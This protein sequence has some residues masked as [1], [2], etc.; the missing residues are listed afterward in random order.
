M[1]QQNTAITKCVNIK[2]FVHAVSNYFDGNLH[3]FATIPNLT[4][5]PPRWVSQKH[6][7]DSKLPEVP[8]FLLSVLLTVLL[9]KASS[10]YETSQLKQQKR[11]KQKTPM[12]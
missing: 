12:E 5:Y 1:D 7:S 9:T 4:W 8:S 3:E 6:D 2:P 11:R 10:A